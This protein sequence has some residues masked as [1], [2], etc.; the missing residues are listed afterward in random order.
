M[1]HNMKLRPQPFSAVKN[2]YKTIEL[3]LYDGKRR[4]IN[5]GDEIVFECTE[6]GDCISKKVTVL[7]IFSDFKEL[8]SKLPLLKCGYT[9][10]TYHSAK[11]EDMAD[12]YPV[13]EQKQ[14]KVVGIELEEKPLQRF[15][16]GHSGLIPD[17]SDYETALAEICRGLKSTHWMWYVFPEIRGLTADTVTEYFAL[18]G[19]SETKAF[20]EHPVLGQRLR[21]IT[22]ALLELDKDDPV[23]I[24]G[25]IDAYKL[26]Y[27]MTL[28]DALYPDDSIFGQ[29]LD[30]Y[31]MGIR[32]EETLS[33]L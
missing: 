11:A 16:V 5:A 18:D 22:S 27:C 13:E 4:M 33:L 31:C 26:R 29:V 10:F 15:L 8:Y 12:F 14:N 3:R 2:G 1:K 30:K 19:L 7:H 25:T 23:S 6:S 20:Y 32:D 9:P 24:F 17:C 21:E 28:F